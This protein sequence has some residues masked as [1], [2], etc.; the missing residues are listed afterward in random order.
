MTAVAEY[1]DTSR[2]LTSLEPGEETRGSSWTRL[3]YTRAYE[4]NRYGNRVQGIGGEVDGSRVTVTVTDDSEVSRVGEIIEGD[5]VVR[6]AI[7]DETVLRSIV[8]N[9]LAG[10]TDQDRLA[11][12]LVVVP[13]AVAPG[14]AYTVD[15]FDASDVAL[16][17][18]KI[19]GDRATL[20]FRQPDGLA[21]AI[22]DAK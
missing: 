19:T 14:Y 6:T 12:E 9:K 1:S 22:A 2:E 15:P 13:T 8:R 20:R 17:S 18:V 5:P 21:S 11:G 16:L 7:T 4:V 10:L 3:D